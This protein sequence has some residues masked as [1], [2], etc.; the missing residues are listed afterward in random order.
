MGMSYDPFPHV[1]GLGGFI[2]S[3]KVHST[4]KIIKSISC[5]IFDSYE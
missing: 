3:A 5:G 2:E 4:K 1:K